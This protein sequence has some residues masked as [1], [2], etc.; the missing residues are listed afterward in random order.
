MIQLKEGDVYGYRWNEEYMKSHFE[1]YHCFDGQLIVVRKNDKLWLED[2]YWSSGR[3]SYNLEDLLNKGTFTLK[4]NLNEVE[5]IKQYDMDYY[6][7]SDVFNISGQ[8]GYHSH[9]VKKIGAQK[10]QAK[11]LEMLNRKLYDTRQT[12]SSAQQREKY[13]QSDIEKVKSGN[14]DVYL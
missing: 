2:T 1:P 11:M 12:I 14:L 3:N 9:F 4:C 6:D 5:E 13:I 8:K 7:D 10:S